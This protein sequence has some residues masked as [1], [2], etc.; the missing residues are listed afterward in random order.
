M[1][2]SVQQPDTRR[3]R[4]ELYN[5]WALM[6]SARLT[7]RTSGDSDSSSSSSSSSTRCWQTYTN[8][9]MKGTERYRDE[10][11]VLSLLKSV[12]W[13]LQA[14]SFACDYLRRK[15]EQLTGFYVRMQHENACDIAN[16]E[17]CH[18]TMLHVSTTL[19]TSVIIVS[20]NSTTYPRQLHTSIHVSRASLSV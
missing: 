19:V 12:N 17:L 5:V 6:S 9:N 11:R 16:F 3:Q 18:I 15:N 7:K 2:H 20:L 14:L 13:K 4:T 1:R 10:D 8:P